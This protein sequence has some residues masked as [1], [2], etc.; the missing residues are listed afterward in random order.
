MNVTFALVAC[1][2]TVCKYQQRYSGFAVKMFNICIF[3]TSYI[4][5]DLSDE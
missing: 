3:C 2:D 4:A 1:V 5:D